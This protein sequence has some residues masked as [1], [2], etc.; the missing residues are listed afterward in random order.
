MYLVEVGMVINFRVNINGELGLS[1]VH[2]KIGA[3]AHDGISSAVVC[4]DQC[5]NTAFP[6]GRALWRQHP[7]H[8][9]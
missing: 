6:V 3:E 7:Q 4:I 8:V 1:S 9:D 2:Y 5:S